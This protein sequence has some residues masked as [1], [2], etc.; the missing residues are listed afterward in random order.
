MQMSVNEIVRSYRE[1]KEPG[2]QITILAEL[3]C[4]TREDIYNILKENGV[5]INRRALNGG[6]S[7]SPMKSSYSNVKPEAPKMIDLSTF[8]VTGYPKE[9]GLLQDKP[10]ETNPGVT[11]PEIV[12][13]QVVIELAEREI[14]NIVALN[15]GLIEKMKAN[16]ARMAELR[17][18]VD[19]ARR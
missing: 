4:C 9:N 13:P 2:K 19:K 7:K 3:N 12:I 10:K 5:D 16:D 8:K 11:N 17:A 6:N 14:R 15:E 18:F 1:A